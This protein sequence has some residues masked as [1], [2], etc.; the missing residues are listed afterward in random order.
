M[1]RRVLGKSGIEVS[2]LGF[3]CWAIGGPAWRDGGTI[4]WGQVDDD[5]SIRAI[6]KAMD[7][8][9]NFFDTADVYGCGHSEEVLGKALEG[10]REEAVI[11]TKFGF[12]FDPS[13]K[14]VTGEHSDPEYIRAACDASL[15]RLGADHIDLYQYHRGD[16]DD[17]AEVRDALEDLVAAG[18]IRAYGWSTDDPDRTRVFAEGEHCAAV[19]QGLSLMGGNRETLAVCEELGLASINR[20]P[21]GMGLLTGKFNR[22][23]TFAEDDVRCWFNFKEGP[24]ADQLEKLGRV[25]EALTADGRTLAQGALGWIWATSANTIPI[26]GFKTVVQA[27]ENAR[28]MT[29]GPLAEET[30]AEI[31]R[32]LEPA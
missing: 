1:M 22:D 12:A 19:Q 7:L 15:Q 25:R 4:R 13:S 20:G 28:A 26:P 6:H 18:K 23:T 27:E 17:G 10:I 2:A 30:M 32:L 21:L 5:E 3:G 14:K 29:F 11:A 8:G 24:F 16:A 31:A 9:V